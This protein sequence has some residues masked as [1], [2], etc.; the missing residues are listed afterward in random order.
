ME[1]YGYCP[2]CR[3]TKKII[4][5]GF[6]EKDCF[7]CKGVGYVD[8]PTTPIEKLPESATYAEPLHVEPDYKPFKAKKKLKVVKNE[9]AATTA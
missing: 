8:K 1:N 2:A 3:G 9:L 6:T 5:M 7:K 4:G